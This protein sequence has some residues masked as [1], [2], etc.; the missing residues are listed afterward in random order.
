MFLYISLLVSVASLFDV[1]FG[2]FVSSE[3]NL[4]M[5]LDRQVC[6]LCYFWISAVFN[7]AYMLVMVA[8]V[9]SDYITLFLAS[10]SLAWVVFHSWNLR[11]CI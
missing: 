8:S 9:A 3:D 11:E 5:F 1:V 10:L 4:E 7:T 6:F 2:P